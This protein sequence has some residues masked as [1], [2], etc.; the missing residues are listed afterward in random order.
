M[1]LHTAMAMSRFSLLA[2][3]MSWHLLV[4]AADAL[5]RHLTGTWGTAESLYAGATGQT[6]LLLL[7]DGFG[8]M[9]G[10][11]P[12]A[13]RI[14]GS[15]DGKVAPRAIIGFPLRATADGDTITAKP[16]LPGGQQAEKMARITISCRYEQAGPTL[17]CL[18][19]SGDL[20]VMSR[21]SDTVA[22]EAA[23]MIEALRP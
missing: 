6:E 3:C 23:K 17:T 22:P 8:A 11:T 9:Q 10:S 14:D 18:G 21:R 16:F 5:P 19:P 20:M 4:H 12:P 7:A 13:T 15:D 1:K 2:L